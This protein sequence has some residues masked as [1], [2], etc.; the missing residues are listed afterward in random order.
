MNK[1]WY[2]IINKLKLN[3]T[4]KSVLESIISFSNKNGYC[5]PSQDHIATKANVS[6]QT[7]Q[8]HLKILSKIKINGLP[9]IRVFRARHKDA[10]Y[11]NNRYFIPFVKNPD[12]YISEINKTEFQEL[13]SEYYD[14]SIEDQV[15]RDMDLRYGHK[16]D[17]FRKQV[18]MTDIKEYVSGLAKK[19]NIAPGR[20]MYLLANI[21]HQLNDGS[22]VF[23]LRKYIEKA[24]INLKKDTMVEESITDIYNYLGFN[25]LDDID[26]LSLDYDTYTNL[27]LEW[28]ISP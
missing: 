9:L 12:P 24:L 2:N 6:K 3:P 7:V 19:L 18:D 13:C 25:K 5:Y 11:T 22:P 26:R 1:I 20:I 21:G 4:T 17:Q 23:N 27:L 8:R 16:T 15:E 10:K 14:M 28:Q